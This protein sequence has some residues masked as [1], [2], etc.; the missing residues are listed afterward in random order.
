MQSKDRYF[1]LP[2]QAIEDIPADVEHL[3][4]Y[5]FSDYEKNKL[6]FSNNSFPQ[7]ES[8]TIGSW[9]FQ[10]V[11][12][13]VIDGL[14]SLESVRIGEKSFRMGWG[15]PDDGICLIK[16]CPNLRQLEI[17]NES[18]ADFHSFEIYSVNS[19]QSIKFGYSCFPFTEDFSLKG[20][21]KEKKC[22]LN[23][24]ENDELDLPSL[25]TVTFG[26]RSFTNC[27]IAVFESM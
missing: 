23:D 5:G 26:D 17:D 27:H 21:W 1:A 2:N 20:K 18:F 25:E 14:A 15:N 7:L 9:C 8:I 4:L 22:D 11:R 24:N 19:L 16:N 3:Y 6:I 10:D 12:E 13:L